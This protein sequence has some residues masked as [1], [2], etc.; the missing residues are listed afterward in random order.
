MRKLPVT[1]A[2]LALLVLTLPIAAE[3]A[4]PAPESPWKGNLGLS[5]LATSGN[6]DTSSFG[7]DL[8][9]ER[10]PDPWGFEVVALFTRADENGVTTAERYMAGVRGK[11][12][13]NERWDLFAG[14]SGEKDEFAGYDLLALFEVGA[15]YKALTGPRH[16]LSFDLGATYTDESRIAP[17][18]DVSYVGAVAGLAYEWK[19]SETASFTERLLF[20]P[21]LDTSDDWRASSVTA[22]QAAISSRLAVK[23]GYEIRYR[24]QPIGAN[25]D[26]DTTTKVSLVVN[27]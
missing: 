17:A 2:A 18:A 10:T 11:R 19:I 27:L 9:L 26:T 13:L 20:Y 3:D 8:K 15:T 5:Y 16:L 7:L 23:V 12:A 4:A 22:L 24:N 14:L 6:T 21:N 25:D 1:L